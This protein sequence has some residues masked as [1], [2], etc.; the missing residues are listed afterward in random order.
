MIESGKIKIEI[1]NFEIIVGKSFVEGNY[2]DTTFGKVHY[3][4]TG[5]HVVP[6]V[7]KE[8]E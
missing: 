8:V 2:I 4:R 1:T 7:K 5:T 3:S 6:Y